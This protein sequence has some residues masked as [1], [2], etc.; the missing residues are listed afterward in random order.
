MLPNV[1]MMSVED[2]ETGHIQLINTTKMNNMYMERRGAHRLAM[3]QFFRKHGIDAITV[4][5]NADYLAPIIRYF[6]QRER[7]K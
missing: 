3:H 7:N 5:T 6:K 1:G 4:N 2:P